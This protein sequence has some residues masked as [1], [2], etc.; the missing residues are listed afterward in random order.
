MNQA[1]KNNP[2]IP[3]THEKTPNINKNTD[4]QV[5]MIAAHVCP[6]SALQGNIGYSVS[7]KCIQQ[8]KINVILT[9]ATNPV[10][11]I[12]KPKL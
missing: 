11:V 3:T 5:S 6:G 12:T 7:F 1:G 8:G 9:T 10:N 4:G 2:T